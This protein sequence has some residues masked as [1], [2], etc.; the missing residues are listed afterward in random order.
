MG[1]VEEDGGLV[2]L[3]EVELLPAVAADG[4]VE[5]EEDCLVVVDGNLVAEEE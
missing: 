4:L 3:E 5:V 2:E 1:V